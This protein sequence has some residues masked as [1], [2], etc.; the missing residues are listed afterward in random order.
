M[1]HDCRRNE[2]DRKED[3]G[4]ADLEVEK[5]AESSRKKEYAGYSNRRLWSWDFHTSCIRYV[6]S[7]AREVLDSV[8]DKET[9][10]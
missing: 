6:I 4:K 9:T 10:E 2:E 8:I 3:N 1:H 5:D 7:E